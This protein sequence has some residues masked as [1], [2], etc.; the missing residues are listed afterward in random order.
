MSENIEIEYNE[1]NLK[2]KCTNDKSDIIKELKEHKLEDYYYGKLE[3]SIDEFIELKKFIDKSLDALSSNINLNQINEYCNHDIDIK[4][5]KQEQFVELMSEIGENKAY[6][7][8]AFKTVEGYL[9]TFDKY[10]DLLKIYL[11]L[12]SGKKKTEV[13]SEISIKLKEYY[14]K[15]QVYENILS[16]I[17]GSR[18]AFETKYT[19]LSRILSSWQNANSVN[20]QYKNR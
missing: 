10:I 18:D 16:K 14:L 20:T 3:P 13:D 7:D 9:K 2:E 15:R 5:P 11:I 12:L 19:T 8:R 4:S 6:F 17:A 1:E